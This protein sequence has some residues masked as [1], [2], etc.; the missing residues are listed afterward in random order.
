[1]VYQ[2]GAMQR[3]LYQISRPASIRHVTFKPNHGQ[4]FSGWVVGDKVS[5]WLEAGM[6]TDFQIGLCC[7]VQQVHYKYNQIIKMSGITPLSLSKYRMRQFLIS[8]MSRGK[9]T[10]KWP[11]I[12]LTTKW[13]NQH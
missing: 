12:V 2:I 8:F 6:F 7:I 9:A 13:L 11:K 5:Q 4:L 1:M 10:L 3:Q